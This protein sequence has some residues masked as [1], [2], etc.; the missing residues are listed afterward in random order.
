MVDPIAAPAGPKPPGT[1]GLIAITGISATPP[2]YRS[3]NRSKPD[4]CV[5]TFGPPVEPGPDFIFPDVAVLEAPAVLDP[6]VEPGPERI[7]PEVLLD[8]DGVFDPPVEPGPDFILL[9]G[10]AVFDPP[11]EPGPDLMPEIELFPLL[12][13]R[14]PLEPPAVLE[15]PVEPGPDFMPPE[16]DVRLVAPGAPP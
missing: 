14:D 13:P 15:P 11:V 9:G 4:F 2:G 7:E 12:P 10:D 1:G 3:E 16:D 5:A 6:P 8:E